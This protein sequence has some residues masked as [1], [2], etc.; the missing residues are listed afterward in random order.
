MELYGPT[1]TNETE[2]FDSNAPDGWQLGEHTRVVDGR[3]SM[4]WEEDNKAL[5]TSGVLDG[6]FAWSVDVEQAGL[7]DSQRAYLYFNYLDAANHYALELTASHLRLI[8]KL[9][10]KETI[11]REVA[12]EHPKYATVR[13]EI[14]RDEGDIQVSSGTG[15]TLETVIG[16]IYDDRITFGIAGVGSSYNAARFDNSII[17]PIHL[18]YM[19]EYT[20]NFNDQTAQGWTLNG[21]LMNENGFL[22]GDWPLATIGVYNGGVLPSEYEYRMKV[23]HGGVGEPQFSRMVFNYRDEQNYDVLDISYAKLH[24]RSVREGITQELAPEQPLTYHEWQTVYYTI[25]KED[26]KIKVTGESNG[27]SRIYFDQI[28]V[29]AAGGGKIGV[30]VTWAASDF[31]DIEV[32]R[33]K[34]APSTFVNYAENFDSGTAPGWT[35][36]GITVAGD[37]LKG[38]NGVA[39]SVYTSAQLPEQFRYSVLVRHGGQNESNKSKLFFNYKDEQNYY[40]VEINLN[41]MKLKQRIEGVETELGAAPLTYGEWWNITYVVTKSNGLINVKSVYEGTESTLTEAPADPL[42][43]GGNIA[44]GV[45]YSGS[46]FDDITVTGL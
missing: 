19:E 34:S 44:V 39:Q 18:E 35:L 11:L 8:R 25:R 20:E 14:R 41:G 33:L 42:L 45:E 27:D 13:Y 6:A 1:L 15:G 40:V 23:V 36:D 16:D 32:R 7:D 46:D 29:V 21:I 30:G 9:H 2:S 28:P 38:N 3:L 31:D 24:L 10:N 17:G 4:E 22:K 43:T 26:G 5:F 12:H 37:H